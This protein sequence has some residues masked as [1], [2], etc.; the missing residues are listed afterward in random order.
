MQQKSRD[1]SEDPS[2]NDP[3]AEAGDDGD[4]D[5][6]PLLGHTGR[7]VNITEPNLS[8]SYTKGPVIKNLWSDG[9]APEG[10][11]IAAK[12]VTGYIVPAPLVLPEANRTVGTF[13]ELDDI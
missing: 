11:R 2:I 7:L 4:F 13:G 10:T 3:G 8:G 9:D 6:I 1:D 5:E 12:N